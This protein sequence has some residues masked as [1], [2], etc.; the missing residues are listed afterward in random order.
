V[1]LHETLEIAE[2][3]EAA[4]NACAAWLLQELR[5]IL[6]NQPLARIAI[7]GGS[8]PKPMFHT[9]AKTPFDWSHV[10]IYWVDERCVPP[11]DDQ[12]NYKLAKEV[13][14]DPA[15]LPPENIHRIAGELSPEEA[16]SRYVED[17]R[18][19][20]ELGD[21]ALPVFDIVHRGMGP[22]A[23]TASLFPGEPLI[24]DRTG[25][26]A[27]VYVKKLNSHRVTLLPGVLMA[28]NKTVVLTSGDDKAEPLFDVLRGPE[29][30]FRFPCQI[31]TRGALNTLWFIDRA[32]A[33]KL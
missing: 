17:I 9:L 31:A 13:W 11:T 2:S 5:T 7:S 10:H 14:L 27:A 33:A 3:P 12:S 23:H 1:M 22:D 21:G 26:A 29:D 28:A 6:A 15:K 25:T 8:S 18:K 24:A 16:A 4:A 20:F 30:P 32:A 19:G